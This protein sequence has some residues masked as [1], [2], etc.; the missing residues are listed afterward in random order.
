MKL[1]SQASPNPLAKGSVIK[2]GTKKTGNHLAN[3]VAPGFNNPY[4]PSPH[5][6]FTEFISSIDE[7]RAPH[8]ARLEGK[9]IEYLRKSE[10][11]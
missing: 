2:L 10:R 7:K 3:S 4:T 5:S 8:P 6:S 9:A 11:N 1:T